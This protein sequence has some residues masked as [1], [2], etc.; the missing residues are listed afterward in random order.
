MIPAHRRPA[1]HVLLCWLIVVSVV[2]GAGGDPRMKNRHLRPPDHPHRSSI[3]IARIE[4]GGAKL[5]FHS[6]MDTSLSLRAFLQKIRTMQLIVVCFCF[7]NSISPAQLGQFCNSK[8]HA[9]W[10]MWVK[11]M[12]PSHHPPAPHVPLTYWIV[13]SVNLG[14]WGSPWMWYGHLRPPRQVRWFIQSAGKMV[15]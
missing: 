14:V 5:L 1:P 10:A 15:I 3:F 7:I 12:I 6:P 9:I 2:F 4:D 8:M 13:V 11:Q